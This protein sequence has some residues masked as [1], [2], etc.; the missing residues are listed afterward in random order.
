MQRACGH[1]SHSYIISLASL[2]RDFFTLF[3]QCCNLPSASLVEI[4]ALSSVRIGISLR[5]R[6]SGNHVIEFIILCSHIARPRFSCAFCALCQSPI[7]VPRRNRCVFVRP[8]RNFIAI[9]IFGKSRDRI[10]HFMYA[11]RSPD[12]FLHFLRNLP[13]SHPHPSSKSLRF[14]PSASEFHRDQDFR[15]ITLSNSSFYVCISLARDFL[16]VAL[17]FSKNRILFCS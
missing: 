12:I 11:Y 4:V 14:R 13:I 9:T 7:R 3:M 15:K 16:A 2:A 1:A 6:F 10:P 5:S 17:F 8:H